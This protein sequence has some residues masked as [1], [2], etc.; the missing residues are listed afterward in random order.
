MGTVWLF[1]IHII[2]FICLSS[3][4]GTCLHIKL[5]SVH[6]EIQETKKIKAKAIHVVVWD[7]GARKSMGAMGF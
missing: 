7:F 4:E 1:G 3:A 2:M 5:S 6:S